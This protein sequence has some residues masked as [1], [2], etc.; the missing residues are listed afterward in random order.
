MQRKEVDFWKIFYG[1]CYWMQ[2]RVL[3]NFF[4]IFGFSIGLV[5]HFV[6]CSR[7]VCRQGYQLDHL[8]RGTAYNRLKV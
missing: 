5:G 2:L 1:R 3:V 4:E 6:S 8:I 7:S